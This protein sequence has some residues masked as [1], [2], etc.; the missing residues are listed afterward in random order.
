MSWCDILNFLMQLVDTAIFCF[1]ICSSRFLFFFFCVVLACCSI[2]SF[3]VGN[4]LTL[5]SH[6]MMLSKSRFKILWNKGVPVYPWNGTLH[7]PISSWQQFL[8]FILEDIL[9]LSPLL[10][11]FLFYFFSFFFLPSFLSFLY[12]IFLFLSFQFFFFVIFP[13]VPSFL[14]QLLYLHG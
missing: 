9:C 2:W 13:S 6:V 12:L 10:L 1:I 5:V 8:S 4:Y 3:Y 11:S 7:C 14:F